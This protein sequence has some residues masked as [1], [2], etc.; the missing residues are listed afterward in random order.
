MVN[1]IRVR[2]LLWYALVLTGVV[3]G[4]ALLLYYEVESARIKELDGDLESVAAGLESSCRSL[5]ADLL[6]APGTDGPRSRE[7]GRPSLPPIGSEAPNREFH[8]AR[9]TWPGP[10]N[11]DAHGKYFAIY[12]ADGKVVKSVGVP[13]ERAAPAVSYPTQSFR[14]A[15][16]EIVL[17]GPEN[18]TILVGRPAEAVAAE[19]RRFAWQLV[20]T[21]GA[22]LGVGLLGGWIISRRIFRPV[23]AISATAARITET[24]L[25]ERID[26]ANLDR[27][28]VGLG[29]VLN[30]TFDRLRAAFDRQARFT[31]DASHELRTPLAVIRSQAEL[32]L[33][34]ARSPEEYRA[35]IQTTL[36]AAL[37]MSSL[38]ER[39]LV[40]ARTESNL[41]GLK[42]EI[43]EWD[44]AIRAA[45]VQL[46]SFAEKKNVRLQFDLA[47]VRLLGDSGALAQL[48][49]NL[50][51]NA[52]KYNRPGG[53]VRV[54]LT[55][56]PDEILLSVAD[57]GIGIPQADQG[58]IFE[59]F[60][61][62]DKARSRRSGG[63][64]LGLAI[65]KAIVEAHGGAIQFDSAPGDG[66]TFRVA[67]PN[68]HLAGVSVA[69]VE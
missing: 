28:L 5:P 12:R 20:V 60:Y 23:A 14:G 2:L 15:N 39:L 26:T 42:L 37:R 63:S 11:A 22:V 58:K 21:G 4:F 19:M 47:P 64:G 8:L 57:T 10:P 46:A 3:A 54:S 27:E 50:I 33:S 32:V 36:H 7:K 68:P 41:S 62:A 48:A 66:T 65:C 16:R 25:S 45:A 18:V 69:S 24:N 49:V 31:A 6:R 40:L 51:G 67:I 55:A 17:K 29:A 30:E 13:S 38:V 59:R 61:R 9:I 35:A 34:R 56:A 53:R 43:V 1:S 44:G 52:I